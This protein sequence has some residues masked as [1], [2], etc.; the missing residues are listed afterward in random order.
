VSQTAQQIGECRQRIEA[1]AVKVAAPQQ[2]IQGQP[3]MGAP[4]SVAPQGYAQPPVQG[5]A[6]PAPQGYQQPP[7]QG[8]PAPAPMAPPPAAA[9]MIQGYPAPGQPVAQ[10]APAAAPVA[11]AGPF[12]GGSLLGNR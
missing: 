6:Q 9:P 12:G 10:P 11:P 5:Y 3:T 7:M 8:Y 2:M 4:P 1:A